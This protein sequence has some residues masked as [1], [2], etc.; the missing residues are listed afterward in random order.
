[1]PA[2]DAELPTAPGKPAYDGTLTEQRLE[3]AM[4]YPSGL[5]SDEVA[6]RAAETSIDAER[7]ELDRRSARA[8]R[9]RVIAGGL[10]RLELLARYTRLSPV[11]QTSFGPESGS[12]VVT[13]S[14]PG[15]LPPGAP[16]V[17]VSGSAFSFPQ[18]LN[19]YHLQASLRVP[20]SD[21][22]FSLSSAFAATTHSARAAELNAK[23]AR[24][25]AAAQGRIAYYEWVR[26]ELQ[27]VVVAQSLGQAKANLERTRRAFGAGRASRADVLGGESLVAQAELLLEQSRAQVRILEQRLRVIMHDDSN[28]RYKI[29]ERISRPRLKLS[30][31]DSFENLYREAERSRLEMRALDEASHALREGGTVVEARG[32]PRLEAFAN[33]YYARPNQ[34]FIPQEDEWR[35]SWDLGVQLTWSPNDL[36]SAGSEAASVRTERRQMELEKS[37]FKDA[38][39]HEVLS[40]LATLEQAEIALASA[41]KSV[42]AAEQ[43]YAVQR[44]LYENGR[45]TTLELLQAD[46][47][48]L[49]ARVN[50]I[51]TLI[52][53]HTA[54]VSLDH[55]VGRDASG[56]LGG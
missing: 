22:L 36:G 28:R 24:L 49:N 50:L 39:R 7:S 2:Q 37:R 15:P 35:G 3:Q 32:L 30:N 26:A 16:L 1:V 46:S 48:L 20:L 42:Q 52:A 27:S 31:K 25:T 6:R 47:Q 41:Q 13:P 17:G 56:R 53:L 8:D 4:G 14:P 11:E 43:A 38:L 12:L 10:P 51:N 40:A 9:N 55:A 18:I 45:A 5:T 54:S 19:Q 23:A 44:T 21:Y 29:G 34:R 33:A